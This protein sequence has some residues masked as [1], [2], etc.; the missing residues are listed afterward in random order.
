MCFMI[1]CHLDTVML[2]IRYVKYVPKCEVIKYKML[3]AILKSGLQ[4]M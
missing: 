3:P 1:L 2:L 4:S